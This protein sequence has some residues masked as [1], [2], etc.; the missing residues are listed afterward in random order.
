MRRRKLIVPAIPQV[1]VLALSGL[2]ASCSMDYGALKS[3]DQLEEDIPN[4]VVFKFE[5][6]VVDGGD[7]LFRLKA[8][9]GE[10]YETKKITKLEGVEFSEFSRGSSDPVTTG[11]AESAVFYND[12]ENAELS[13]NLVFTSK[14]EDATLSTG[15]IFWNNDKKTLEGRT[16]QLVTV[17]KSDGSRLRGEGFS[18]DAR[19]KSFAFSGHVEGSYVEGAK[20]NS[21]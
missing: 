13:G 7:I 5:H 17:T 21:E 6:T 10:T 18:A 4:T 1:L 9:K 12:S 20:D 19:T 11:T 8:E 16:D 3:P 2:L 14:S 15:Y